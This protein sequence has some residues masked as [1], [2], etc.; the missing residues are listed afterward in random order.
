MQH[1]PIYNAPRDA[2]YQ[3]PV[4]DRIEVFGQIRV[5]HIRVACT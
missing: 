2:L 4:R 5:Y 3:F 1:V